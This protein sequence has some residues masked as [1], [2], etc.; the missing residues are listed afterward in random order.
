MKKILDQFVYVGAHDDPEELRRHRVFVLSHLSALVIGSLFAMYCGSYGVEGRYLS[1][2]F[3]LGV[4]LHSISLG[5]LYITGRRVPLAVF[6]GGVYV[7]QLFVLLYLLGGARAAPTFVWWASM[8]VMA[9]FMLK[10]GLTLRLLTGSLFAAALVVGW[11]E[12]KGIAWSIYFPE[13]AVPQL[14][15]FSTI[16][17]LAHV[18]ILLFVIERLQRDAEFML[19]IDAST[20]ALTRALN[21]GAFEKRLAQ[22]IR[23]CRLRSESCALALVDLDNFKAI[24]DQF[25]HAAGDEVLKGLVEVCRSSL[26]DSDIVARVGGDEF[27]ILLPRARL[28]SATRIMEQIREKFAAGKLESGNDTPP[29]N[30]SV[31]IG[32]AAIEDSNANLGSAAFKGL[33]DSALYNAKAR[34]RNCVV[35]EKADD[36]SAG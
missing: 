11:L 23:I 27:A 35:A 21:R 6:S 25:G 29:I 9:R 22:E 28:I 13:S 12:Y 3:T 16:L 17:C 32:V 2:V 33:A 26:R 14:T 30:L 20:D 18:S 5:L 7:M 36:P 24:N 8:P 15:V 10:D 34:G 1:L 31:S 19:K 4:I